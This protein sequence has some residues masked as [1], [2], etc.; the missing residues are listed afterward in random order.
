M[1]G[2]IIPRG[3]KRF[4]SA[5]GRGYEL[6]VRLAA[7]TAAAA[8]AAAAEEVDCKLYV[9]EVAKGSCGVGAR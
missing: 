7:A 1:V 3:L 4:C 6:G 8:A 5:G 9:D 2:G